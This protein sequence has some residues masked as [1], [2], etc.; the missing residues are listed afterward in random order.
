MS[1]RTMR[2][3]VHEAEMG[4]WDGSHRHCIQS[5]LPRVSLDAEH[6]LLVVATFLIEEFKKK[7]CGSVAVDL[8]RYRHAARCAAKGIVLP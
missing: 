8:L 3:S 4:R 5:A 6:C 2:I 1:R 7:G